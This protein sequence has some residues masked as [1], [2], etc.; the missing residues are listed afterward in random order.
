MPHP[1]LSLGAVLLC[2]ACTPTAKP[3]MPAAPAYGLTFASFAPLDTDIFIANADG[4]DAH[5]LAGN[6]ALDYDASFAPDGRS[7]VFTSTR[8]GS[9]DIYEV[10]VD[11]TGLKRLTEDPAFDAQGVLS[12]DGRFLAFTSS[13]SGQADIWIEEL[14]TGGLR[15]LTDHPGGDFRPA[16]S[17]D[18]QWIAF[19]SDRDSTGPRAAF[20]TLHAT[21]LYVVR[22]DGTQLRRVTHASAFAGSPRWSADGRRLFY[23]EASIDE[24]KKITSARR[25]RGTTQIAVIDL[26]TG[27]REVL[28]TGEGEK[29]SPQQLPDLRIA[30]ASGGPDGGVEL[31]AGPAGAR[32]EIRNP[33]W[34]PDGRRMVFQRDTQT[35]WPPLRAWPSRSRLVSLE[36]TGI[37][38]ASSRRD[39]RLVLN[40]QPAGA[41]HNSIVEMQPD[42]S[43]RTVVFTDAVKNSLGPVWSPS[44]DRIAFG[45]GTYFQAM[46]GPAIADIAVIDADGGHLEILTDGTSNYGMPS[47]SP[48]GGRIVC[49]VGDKDRSA[50]AIID[51]RTHAV[52]ALTDGSA[53]DNFPVWSPAGASIAF[54][55]DRGGDYDIYAIH[56]DGSGLA[57]LTHSPGNDAHAAWSPDGA[58]LAF[59]SAR[60]GF[61]DEAPL[62]PYNAQPYGDLYVMRADGSDVQMITDDQF[63]EGTPAW[64]APSTAETHRTPRSQ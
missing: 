45:L 64:L 35:T 47:W 27:E 38:A 56:P 6:P 3:A 13:R 54:T 26:A 58:W 1:W 43:G 52:T 15:N 11:G 18:G 20:V 48:D 29:W 41:L 62:H 9:A 34:S 51:V 25:T 39:H 55:S 59:T 28:T 10:G 23:Y 22:A 42:G 19:S 30:Y 33:Q 17:P 7:V 14:A 32:G 53:R 4:T 37:F 57:Q 49:R 60:G 61:K 5:V 24:V 63:E 31:V 8:G 21:E 46:T 50:L 36:R 12:P 2:G 44:G 40:D 16:W